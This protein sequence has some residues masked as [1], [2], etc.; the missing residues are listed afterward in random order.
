MRR[1]LFLL[2]LVAAMVFACAGVVLAQSTEQRTPPEKGAQASN[3]RVNADDIE[4]RGP[5]ELK[6]PSNQASEESVSGQEATSP[7]LAQEATTQTSEQRANGAFVGPDVWADPATKITNFT[8]M[9]GTPPHVIMYYQNWE[10]PEK[11]YFDPA[12]M[13]TVVN[14]GATPMV[15]WAPRDPALGKKQP[16]YALKTIVAG[17]HDSYIRQ[18]AKD[19]AAWGKSCQATRRLASPCTMYLRFAHEMNGTWFPWSPGV[20]GN[21]SSEFRS[22]WKRIHGIFQQEGATNVRWVWSPYVNCV[23]CSSFSSVYPGNA[24]VDWVALDGYNWGTTLSGSSWQSMAQVFGSSYDAVTALA[25]TKPFMIP[26]V[27]SAEKGGNKA[28]WIRNAFYRDIP[29]RLPK[30]KAVVW[31]SADFTAAGETDW[32]VNSS[33]ASLAAYKEVAASGSYQGQLP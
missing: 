8:N 2:A 15:T 10:Q 19:A 18:W 5:P 9:V 7:T 24:Y 14:K 32:R 20:N 6:L 23:G 30:T 4:K 21:T 33:A 31:F 16:E 27:S 1:A 12:K 29:N 13:Q 11:K 28:E 26:E 25:P 22:A 3:S 17:T